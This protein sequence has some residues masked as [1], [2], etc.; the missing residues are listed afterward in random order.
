MPT[1]PALRLPQLLQRLPLWA[2]VL[3]LAAGYSLLALLFPLGPNYRQLPLADIRT[4]TPSLAAGGL[5]A[6]L[7]LA[8]FGLYGLAH[9]RVRE[10]PL[11]LS[12]LL[13]TTLLF[14][15]PLLFT[16]PINA[17]DVYR[18]VIRGR[19]SSAYG[20]NPFAVPPNQF[21]EDPFL[22][23]AG[24]WAGETSPYGPVWEMAAAGITAVSGDNL[25][26][27][28]LLF[29]GL[30]LLLHLA[31]TTHIWHMARCNNS[32]TDQSRNF[33]LQS[34]TALLWAWNPALLLNFVANAHNDIFMLGWLLL[35]SLLIQRQR[36]TTGFLF[37]TLAPLSKPIGLLPIPF[38]WLAGWRK[39]A[40]KERWRYT[41]V[42]VGGTALLALLAFAP[43]GSPLGLLQRLLRE[44]SAVGGF[45]LSA[46]ALLGLRAMGSS[47]N[48]E[49]ILNGMRGV[50]ILVALWQVWLVW[51]G[52]SP[53]RSAAN[54]FIAYMLT[55]FSF[56]IWY[57]SW[58][59]PW[60]LLD[61]NRA[62][63]K[64]GLLL[65]LTTQ[66][67]VL[68]YGH[69]RAYALGGS[70][71]AAHLIGVPFTFLLPLLFA[72]GDSKGHSGVHQT[73]I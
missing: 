62:R 38:F 59:I 45:S 60:L 63:R 68:I 49:W 51:N 34:S 43:F 42:T 40:G 36:P 28:L 30:G 2:V 31:A 44:A 72:R 71:L 17:T 6:L 3:L 4:F 13:L 48:G 70:Q 23:L 67:S 5:Y 10:R 58:P 18:Y 53:Q 64:Y 35:G 52:R 33:K 56:R 22:S 8:L 55:A 50:F 9:G 19:V 7:L 46:L 27:G 12:T 73:K 24:E 16:F 66:L 15:L 25:L 20:A 54:I 39:L 32:V 21:P 11:P 26:L 1:A 61:H 29:K 57:A 47:L 65:L 14:S 37:M 41:A 69:L